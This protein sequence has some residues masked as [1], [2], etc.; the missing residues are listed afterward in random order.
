[1]PLNYLGLQS[2]LL[3][4]LMVLGRV[5]L[6]FGARVFHKDIRDP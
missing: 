3:R 6:P 2:Y 4:A 5:V 1:M